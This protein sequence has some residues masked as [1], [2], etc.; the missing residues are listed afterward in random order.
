VGSAP[1]ES[2][3]REMAE[4]TG[5]ACEFATPHES[6]AEA[7]QRLLTRIRQALP[8]QAHVEMTTNALWM[9]T[10]PRRIAAGETVHLFMRL[11]TRPEVA[12]AL[13]VAGQRNAQAELSL[14]KDDLVARLVAARQIGMITDK[15]LA[16]ETAER[17]QLV[18]E[19]TNLLL[20]IERAEADKTDGMPALHKVK[21]MVAAG[22]SG[23]S[24]MVQMSS[25]RY[26]SMSEPILEAQGSFITK[27]SYDLGSNS[28][29]SVWRS[30]RSQSA[31]MVDSLAS[32]GMDDFEIPAF[33]RKQSGDDQ[34]TRQPA[35]KVKVSMSPTGRQ[36]ATTAAQ[37]IEAFNQ[38]AAQG[39]AFRPALR[40]VT[41]LPLETWL[42]QLIVSASR[43]AG[44]PVKSWACYLLWL[45]EHGT[46]G[47][48]LNPEA[49]A[50]VEGQVKKIDAQVRLVIEQAFQQQTS[51]VLQL[52]RSNDKKNFVKS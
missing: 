16:R 22:W 26:S 33:L 41:D 11:P 36:R 8:V 18:T 24:R 51:A 43:Q 39:L 49:L 48:T 19:E 42:C 1:A 12:P 3:L 27:A 13:Q 31:A 34:R 28:V 50:L 4:S 35:S 10:L 46:P 38:A 6:M 52:E 9:S 25:V 29:P 17:Y 7:V 47:L 5:G 40:A 44:G 21:P 32:G 37:L 45:H 20:V 30:N 2:L 23:A 15:S 14:R